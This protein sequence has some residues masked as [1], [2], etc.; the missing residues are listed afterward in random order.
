MPEVKFKIGF[1]MACGL[2]TL[3]TCDITK[4]DT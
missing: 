1:S 3:Y 2:E 4:S